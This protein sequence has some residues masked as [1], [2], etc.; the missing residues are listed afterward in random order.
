MSARTPWLITIGAI[1]LAL[2]AGAAAAADDT[3]AASVKQP[4]AGGAGAFYPSNREPL[5][6]SPFAKLPIGAIKP[7]GWLRRSLEIEADGMTGRLTE[8]SQYCKAEGNAWLSPEGKGHSPWEEL[9]YWLKGFGDLGYVLGDERIMAEAR[10]WIEGILSSQRED[11]WFGPRANLTNVGRKSDIWPNMLAL[12]ALQSY[13]EFSG[14]KRVLPFMLKY[15][16]WQQSV[17]EADFISGSW[18]KI[19]AGDNL[20]SIYWL[21]NRTGEAWLLDVAAKVHARTANWT[22]GVADWHGVNISQSFREP[23][24]FYMQARE[25]RFIKAACRNYDTV[26]GIY[27]QVPGGGFGADE[28]CRPGYVDPRQGTETCT[29]VEFMHSFQ[30]LTRITGDPL[31]ADR[32]EEIAFNSFPCSQTPDQKALHYLTAPNQPVLDT[33]NHAPGIQNEGNMLGYDP[34]DFRCCQHNV[35]MGWPYYAEELWLATADGGLAASLYAPSEVSAKAGDGSQVRIV[36]ETDYPV[37]GTVT[38]TVSAPRR[39]GVRFPLYLRIPRWCDGARL[40][41]NGKPVD[42]KATPLSYAVVDRTWADGDKVTLEL[43]MRLAATVWEKNKNAVSISRGPLTFALK[44]GEK[45]SRCGGTDAPGTGTARAVAGWPA[46]EAH[47][48]TPWNYGLDVDPKAPDASVQVTAKKK[49]P[50]AGLVFAQ[51]AAPIEL[52]ASARRIPAWTLDRHSLAAVLQMSPAFTEQPAEKVTLIPMGWA[53]LR[54]S[55]FPTVSTAADA[56]KWAGDPKA[57]TRG[58]GIVSP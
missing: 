8:I 45:W 43:P 13:Y 19:R 3:V 36:E 48:T 6:A 55:A 34:H 10:K 16:R 35:A 21:Y 31:W 40:S 32:C 7:K 42:I 57:D 15:F 38:L 11:G 44:I 25:D 18:Q 30:M 53:R 23:A 41:I 51:E 58:L 29:W 14:D 17:P 24:I 27:G 28:N 4:R 50:D 46:F 54:I 49:M 52:T 37:D 9:P 20:E 5:L 33:R 56:N 39:A 2:A 1:I 12:N 22:D 26:T 47:P